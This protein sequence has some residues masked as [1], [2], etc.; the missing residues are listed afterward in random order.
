MRAPSCKWFAEQ[1][2]VKH[3]FFAFSNL[4]VVG[5]MVLTISWLVSSQPMTTNGWVLHT[6]QVY[7]QLQDVEIAIAESE[8]S[9]R[10][11]LITGDRDHL[12]PFQRFR[13]SV[14]EALATVAR[15]TRDNPVQRNRIL[16]LLNEINQRYLD[17]DEVIRLNRNEGQGP[18]FAR[19]KK[20][21]EK[22]R[23]KR[24]R[25]MI[26]EMEDEEDRL[27][28]ERD[29]SA[30]RLLVAIFIGLILILFRDAIWLWAN[31]GPFV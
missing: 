23:P 10:G 20:N 24:I 14:Y 17:Q 1:T 31:R 5:V 2:P 18:A 21:I 25:D 4:I 16:T 13:G 29:R 3:S 27:L 12:I 8:T 26:H 19:V 15:M 28:A 30:R 7:R 6:Q 22:Q 11:Y 9:Q